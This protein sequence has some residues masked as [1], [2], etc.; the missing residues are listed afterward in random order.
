MVLLLTNSHLPL[1]Q[2]QDLNKFFSGKLV[3]GVFV[4]MKITYHLS[5][6]TALSHQIVRVVIAVGKITWNIRHQFITK[7]PTA[8]KQPY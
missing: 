3:T 8:S 6:C 2:Y 4:G 7:S 1:C 5:G